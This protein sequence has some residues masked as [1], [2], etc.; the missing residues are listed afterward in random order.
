[1]QQRRLGRTG[2]VVSELCLGTMTFG[3]MADEAAS[4]AC[5]D[6]AFDAGVDFI[7]VAERDRAFDDHGEP[8][9]ERG[10]VA[11]FPGLYFVGLRFQHTPVSHLLYGA[12]NDARY[13]AEHIARR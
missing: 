7:D 10:V 5:L 3:S 8:V 6:K 2:L 9:H 12:G 13:I 4:L 11:A 1:M